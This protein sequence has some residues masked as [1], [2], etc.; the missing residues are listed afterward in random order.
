MAAGA[1]GLKR[2]EGA[3]RTAMTGLGATLL[4]RLLAGDGGHRGP[5]V[6]CGGGHDAEFVGYRPK[7]LDTILGP[8]ELSRA[9][10]HCTDCHT[11]A[12]PRDAE[13]G[14]AGVSLTPGL[15]RMVAR[16]AAD[17]P[18]AKAQQDL[19]ELAGIE[20]T[21]KRIERSAEADGQAVAATLEAEAAAVLAGT[22]TP[23]VEGDPPDTLYVTMDG[24]GVPCIPAA[25][26][27]RSG[28]QPDGRAA[29]REVKLACLFTQSGLDD[30]GYAVRDPGSSSYLATFAPAE[31]F[32]T[33]AYA[34]AAR[35]GIAQARRTVVLGD[36][37]AWIWN[38][39]SLHFP[40][41]V[42]IVDLYHARE[43]L[44]ELG[45]LVTPALGN[46][47]RD[48]LTERLEDLDNGDIDK[49]IAATRDLDL[50]DTAELD[51]ALGYF[52]THR[53]RMRY[54]HFRNRGLFVGSGAIEAGCRT[55]VGQRLKLSG[56]RWNIPG[57]TGILTLRSHHASSR[58][59]Q[60]WTR[61]HHTTA[62]A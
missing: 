30:D 39:A 61:L 35:R 59:E 22:L 24:T 26:Q 1:E 21:V 20:L 52:D 10:Y 33:L 36:G 53:T 41:A 31:D 45:R 29:T 15:R 34:E 49:L 18:F 5:R 19:A 43:H 46:N 6:D 40:S 47:H 54:A 12:A 50:P 14:V 38:L 57:A 11:G 2:L 55:V 3:I 13:L 27:G 4:E 58:W 62:A 17:Q 28:K 60:L 8:V 32:G 42:Q 44:H 9:W 37:A 48:W 51:T 25:T 16:V 56:M 23:L 7:H